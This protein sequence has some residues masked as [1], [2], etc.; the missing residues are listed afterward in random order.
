MVRSGKVYQNLMVDVAPTS[1]KL[2]ERAKGLVM[3]LGSVDYTQAER[4]LVASG[5][6]VKH[7]VLVA[8][9]GVS[10]DEAERLLEKAQ[11]RL[12]AALGE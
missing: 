7:A 4:L 5:W 1:A 8:R 2:R 3:H 11:G 6:R 10:V 12:R 9:R